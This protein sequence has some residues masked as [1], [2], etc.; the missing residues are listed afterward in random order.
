MRGR[1]RL[2][3]RRRR[4]A[5]GRPAAARGPGSGEPPRPRPA[6]SPRDSA[7]AGMARE[8][9]GSG[10]RVG[11]C[12]P[13]ATRLGRAATRAGRSP[14]PRGGWRGFGSGRR[15]VG[16]SEPRCR[17]RCAPASPR[18]SRG[19]PWRPDPALARVTASGPPR[20]GGPAELA[21]PGSAR[22]P[23]SV[24]VS[25]GCPPRR[26][27]RRRRWARSR[28]RGQSSGPGSRAS[29]RSSVR[30]P[31]SGSRAALVGAAGLRGL[32][33]YRTRAWGRRVRCRQRLSELRFSAPTPLVRGVCLLRKQCCSG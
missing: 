25:A 27:V 11:A 28:R 30:C 3:K 33:S 7:A 21:P 5:G 9:A 14:G 10:A 26:A 29:S 23:R 24:G 6:R 8:P 13:T 15:G 4:G 19:R 32:G 20:E 22:E 18:S 17:R 16:G 12:A 31:G 1:G 2:N